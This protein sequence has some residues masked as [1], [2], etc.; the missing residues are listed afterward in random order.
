MKIIKPNRVTRS[1]TQHLASSPLEVF[2]LLCPVREA[3]WIEGWDPLLVVSQSGYAEQNCSFVTA[4]LPANAVWYVTRHEPENLFLEMIKI[5]P[6]ITAC[7]L[8]IQVRP[9]QSGSTADVTYMHTSLGPEGDAFVA[10]FTE[11]YY[12]G[13]MADWETRMNDFL[14]AQAAKTS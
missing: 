5:S 11:E 7:R 3:E 10:G 6:G 1:F 8:T 12:A 4:S 9:S 13:F 2:K 14:R